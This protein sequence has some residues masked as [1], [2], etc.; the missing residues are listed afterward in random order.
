[1]NNP[2]W[3]AAKTIYK[4]HHVEDGTPKMVFEERIV[5]FQTADFD[6]AIAKAEAEASEYCGMNNDTVYLGFVNVFHLFDEMVGHGIEVYSL[7]RESDLSEKDYLDHF[8]DNGKER[9]QI[10]EDRA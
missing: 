9:R 1:M 4:H 8:Y 2:E 10:S 6:D 5:L 3:Y 7:M